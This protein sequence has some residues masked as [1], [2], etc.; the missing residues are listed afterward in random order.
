M[1][2]ARFEAPA[3]GGPH[4]PPYREQPGRR[5][6][7]EPIFNA[8]WVVLLLTGAL[9][10]GYAIQSRFPLDAVAMSFA[11]SPALLAEGHWE[12]LFSALFLHG[13]WPHVL[14]NAGFCLAF[15]APVARYF[16]EGLRGAVMFLA[17][18]LACGVLSSL[19]YAAL[20]WGEQSGLVGASGAVSGLMGAAARLMAGRGRVGP[21]LSQTVLGMGAIWFAINAV[22]GQLGSGLL[23]GAGGAAVAW[24]AHIA[25]FVA[26]VLLM[27][28]VDWLH[29]RAERRRFTRA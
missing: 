18:Y 14:M 29:R 17:F 1:P 26:G 20:H 24:E 3:D 10:G 15:G 22:I 9:I 8:P 13:S 25:G 7:P 28:P 12:R 6:A 5:Q 21:I 27:S 19:G 23:P 4:L 11:F 2:V 16:G